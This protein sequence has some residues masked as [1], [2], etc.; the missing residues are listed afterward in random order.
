MVWYATREAVKDALD[1]KE[2]ARSNARIDRALEAASEAVEG[3]TH[4]QFYPELATREVDWPVQYARLWR[5]WLPA[6]L[7]SVT[8]LYTNGAVVPPEQY[9]LRRGDDLDRPPYNRL[10]LDLNTS[11]AFGG[12]TQQRA[13]SITGLW[14]WSD[15]RAPAG[16]AAATAN[17]GD[18]VLTVSATAAIGVGSILSAGAERLEVTGRSMMATGQTLAVDFGGT[19][20][21]RTLVVQDG[22][23]IAQGEMLLVDGERLL[24]E[25]VAG[26]TLVVQRAV[27][28]S[29]LAGHSAGAT[30]WAPRH[31]T[32]TRGVLGTTAATIPEGTAL[33]VWL[34]PGPVRTLT[35]AE[36]TNTLL[37]EQAGYARNVRSASSSGSGRGTLVGTPGLDDLRESVYTS[38]GRKA[39]IGAV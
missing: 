22:T 28:G 34:P 29:V 17:A 32:V 14:G 27:D 24:V 4:R 16:T 5:L 12:T 31:L 6:D 36:A 8:T 30:V 35:I 19:T 11:A 21:A 2:T 13:V 37:Q 25:E 26:D 3:L 15:D 38:H 9:V 39:R 20:A 23:Q 10:E 7:I 18:V 33:S 1:Y